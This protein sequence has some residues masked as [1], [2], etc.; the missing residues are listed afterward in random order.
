MTKYCVKLPELV[1]RMHP[2]GFSDLCYPDVRSLG[3]GSHV[4][5]QT[6]ELCKLKNM[7]HRRPRLV[8]V[9]TSRSSS[10]WPRVVVFRA[11]QSMEKKNS[12]HPNR[13]SGSWRRTP[14]S[15]PPASTS[16][17]MTAG[18]STPTPPTSTMARSTTLDDGP[19]FDADTA[20]LGVEP[21]YDA[22]VDEGPLFDEEQFTE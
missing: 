3:P 2:Q 7:H 9:L 15:V 16:T 18:S 21:V 12:S 22:D 8:H 1:A 5:D 13:S 19:V 20:Y 4:N 6:S 10:R 11:Y 14:S 17:S